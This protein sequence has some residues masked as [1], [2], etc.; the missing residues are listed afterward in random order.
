MYLL[1]RILGQVL[2]NQVLKNQFFWNSLCIAPLYKDNAQQSPRNEP[3]YMDPPG[4]APYLTVL[5]QRHD[6]AEELDVKPE[7]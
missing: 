5:R 4:Y 7:A 2:K 1:Q 3:A 6:P